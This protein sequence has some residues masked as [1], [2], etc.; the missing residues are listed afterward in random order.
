MI[1]SSLFVITINLFRFTFHGD[2]FSFTCCIKCSHFMLKVGYNRS[3][4]WI[5]HLRL[6]TSIVIVIVR[7]VLFTF[8]IFHRLQTCKDDEKESRK[9]NIKKSRLEIIITVNWYGIFFG[10]FNIPLTIKRS[11][12][13]QIWQ[14]FD[15]HKVGDFSK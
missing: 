2:I 1:V 5:G 12:I 10:G 14:C 9:I 11:Q 6:N 4:G 3:H 7:C 13:G 8:L 15:Q